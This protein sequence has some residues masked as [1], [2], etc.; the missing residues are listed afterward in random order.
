VKRKLATIVVALAAVYFAY[1][2][3]AN[4]RYDQILYQP[5]SHLALSDF[6]RMNEPPRPLGIVAGDPMARVGVGAAAG[7]PAPDARVRFLGKSRY[8][9]DAHAVVTHSIDD[10]SPL[11]PICLDT[12]DRYGVKATVFVNTV[13]WG[14]PDELWARL[15]KAAADG[16]EIGSHSRRHQCQRPDTALFC[17][18]AFSDWE[19]AGSRDDI[20][21]HS[22]QPYV[23]S[24]AYPCGSCAD[25]PFVQRKLARTGYLYARSYPNEAQD[26]HNLPNLRTYPANPLSATYTQVVQKR[27]GVAKQGRTD[28]AEVNRVFDEVYNE[29]GIYHFVSHP[30]WLEYGPEHFY[31]QHVKHIGGRNDVWYVPLGPLSAYKTAW[32]KTL[33]RA[34][35]AEDGRERFAVVNDL[36]AKIFGASVTLQFGVP[37]GF[38]IRRAGRPLPEAPQGPTSGWNA[39]YVRRAGDNVFVTVQTNT[40]LDFGPPR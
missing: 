10:T 32:E 31:E 22:G 26:L 39:E 14:N 9:N 19:V 20:L 2:I 17:F 5:I 27:G 8:L 38:E 11:I 7:P 16:H 25:Y 4:L 12:L 33:V 21:S 36:D 1:D 18:R 15:K 3:W 29:G 40:I 6:L 37:A 24:F 35:P 23:W 30:M 28:V 34:L 13:M